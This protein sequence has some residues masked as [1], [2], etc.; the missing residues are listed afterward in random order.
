[1]KEYISVAEWTSNNGFSFLYTNDDLLPLKLAEDQEGQPN[2]WHDVATNLSRLF[3]NKYLV[4]AKLRGWKMEII[5]IPYDSDPECDVA[6]VDITL[7]HPDTEVTALET[8]LIHKMLAHT[9]IVFR[10]ATDNRS[11]AETFEELV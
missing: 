4:E 11:I 9:P 3:N 8:E 6:D 7:L 10:S 2:R 1:M 5:P